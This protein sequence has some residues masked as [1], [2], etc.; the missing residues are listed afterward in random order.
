MTFLPRVLSAIPITL[1]IRK[2]KNKTKLSLFT[3]WSHDPGHSSNIIMTL[4]PFEFELRDV[5]GLDS[6]D[7]RCL[8]KMNFGEE[9]TCRIRTV[10]N[11]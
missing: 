6:K 8:I 4:N 10:Q 5:E 2:K 11:E 1:V 7:I 3:N 9:S